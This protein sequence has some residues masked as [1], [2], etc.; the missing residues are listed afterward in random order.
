MHHA[1]VKTETALKLFGLKGK[2][3]SSFGDVTEDISSSSSSSSKFKLFCILI[4]I[5]IYDYC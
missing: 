4:Q 2:P 5:L 1:T 3:W